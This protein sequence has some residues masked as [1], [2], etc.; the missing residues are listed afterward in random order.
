MIR[1]RT[2]RG[3][4]CHVLTSPGRYKALTA[5]MLLGPGTPMLLQGQEF[6]ASSPFFFFAD[7]QQELAQLV[8]Q[9]RVEFLSQFQGIATPE[10][11]AYLPDPADPETFE[12]SKLDFSERE[13]HA[14]MYQ[15]HRDLLQLRREM[16]SFAPSAA[17]VS[18]ERSSVPKLLCCA[19]WR[20]WTGP[21]AARQFRVL[22]WL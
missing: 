11:Q 18:M 8:S 12:R 20:E 2:P 22:P 3:Q 16:P 9:G 21:I 10:M 14:E 17:A 15:L 5:L 13:Q 4:R 6:A 7:H 19:F 1:W